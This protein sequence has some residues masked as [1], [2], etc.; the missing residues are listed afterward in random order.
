[1]KAETWVR[2]REAFYQALD[3]STVERRAYLDQ[4]AGE[5]EA[6]AE[7]ERLLALHE[8]DGTSNDRLG[9][10]R[11]L[12][13]AALPTPGRRVGR[14]TI[15]RV[16]GSGGMGTVFEALQDEPR[17]LVALKILHLGLATPARLQ[18]FRFEAEVLGN[19]RHPAIA[20]IH[21]AG[22]QEDGGSLFPFFAME[23]VPGARDILTYA[24]ERN[25]SREER[26][27]LFLPVCE[28]VHHGHQKG[29]IHRDLKA[30]NIL[31]DAE[32]RPKVIDFGIARATERERA[33][34]T[35]AGQLVGTLATMSPEQLAG[36]TEEIDARTDVYSLGV[37]LYELLTGRPPYELGDVSI[38][39]ALKRIR[40][41][42]PLR[43]AG[44][45]RELGWVLQRAL[46]KDPARRY[47]SASEL[48]ADLRRFLAQ[49]PVLAGPPSTRYRVAKF[50]RRHR[51]F[52]SATA[53]VIVVLT[54]A[55]VRESAHARSETRAR[56]D[57][58]REAR[59][60]QDLS[61]FLETIFTSVSPAASGSE[62]LVVDALDEAARRID[63]LPSTDP[64]VR[65]AI[66]R[67]IGSSY[68]TVG[69]FAEAEVHL[70]AARTFVEQD[71]PRDD[72][73]A[74]GVQA[75]WIEYLFHSQQHAAIVAQAPELLVLA[76]KRLGVDHADTV[77]IRRFLGCGLSRTQRTDEGESLLR[78]NL[79]SIRRSGERSERY[80]VALLDLSNAVLDRLAPRLPDLQGSVTELEE[81]Q[82][83]LAE[84]LELAREL[85]PA[86][87]YTI[88]AV[89]G[90][91][92][93]ACSYAGRHAEA[94]RL[95]RERLAWSRSKLGDDHFEVAKDIHS[96]SIV[97]ANQER[98]DEAIALGEE[99]LLKLDE[100]Y[101]AKSL[102]SILGRFTLARSL[103]GAG[104]ARDAEV[105]ASEGLE[106][107]DEILPAHPIR[108]K[109]ACLLG[110]VL[111]EQGRWEDALGVL[112]P[113]TDE[114]ERV[115]GPQH[116]LMAS[117][118][119]YIAEARAN[120]GR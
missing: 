46:E 95:G 4:M 53:A 73:F 86:D 104:N 35:Q 14:Y 21:D 22:T 12:L 24:R 116:A 48:A 115:L 100:H 42:E 119:T 85:F 52:L 44:L 101:G 3:L 92:L 94:E 13:K 8:G 40:E 60:A 29:V 77:R 25:L 28:A 56:T 88:Y 63:E 36:R 64:A 32:G 109:L 79:D 27:H 18:R 72:P 93:Q 19:L 62:A 11:T 55:L 16:L 58:E 33:G 120:L 50:V 113:L 47:A 61:T 65:A 38:E 59:K 90:V 106:L 83:M 114:M 69:R 110:E 2:V 74:I 31:V 111:M 102:P 98:F 41:S 99:A 6:R 105:V 118:Q 84:A 67:T 17:R 82:A 112:E 57:A 91:L 39:E 23:L 20:Q 37:V 5:P 71:L 7:V 89:Q 81:V 103:L 107:V 78:V 1:V 54:V 87:H 43:A 68:V 26:L 9:D 49:E 10:P 45:P 76:E 15:Q 30:A 117:V 51:L 34:M 66:H 70:S 96:L 75:S 80:I 97:L 108:P